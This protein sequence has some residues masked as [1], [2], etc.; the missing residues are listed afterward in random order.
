[1]AIL[2][3]KHV[4]GRP[5]ERTISSSTYLVVKDRE[6]SSSINR[7]WSK[8]SKSKILETFQIIIHVPTS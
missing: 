5:F 1:M 8:T 6:F 3:H 4:N 7:P 2:F